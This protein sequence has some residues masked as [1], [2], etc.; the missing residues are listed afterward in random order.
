MNQ[1][2]Y[3]VETKKI[4]KLGLKMNNSIPRDINETLKYLNFEKR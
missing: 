2:S 1:L 3:K 4:L